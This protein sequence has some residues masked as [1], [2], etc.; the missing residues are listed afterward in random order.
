MDILEFAIK[1]ELEGEKYYT[2]QAKI[3]KDNSLSTVFL[4]L[5]KDEN[6]HA[7]ILE[8][9]VNK[10]SFDLKQSETLSEA[11]SVFNDLGTLKNELK[12]VP[13]QLDVY[14]SALENEKESINL[15]RKYLSE[16]TDNESKKV[17]EYLIK[18]EEDHYAIIDQIVTLINHSEEWV[19]SAEFGKREEY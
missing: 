2:E 13:N 16:A 4:L 7:K 19:E 5:A 17:F 12:Q 3:N 15:Y 18:Q 9:K 14:R 11:K 1:M 10:L 8:N 6:I